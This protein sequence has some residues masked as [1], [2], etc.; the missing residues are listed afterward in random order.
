[1]QNILIEPKIYKKKIVDTITNRTSPC[2]QCLIRV[3]SDEDVC[4]L[5]PPAEQWHSEL[6]LY[7]YPSFSGPLSPWRRF[8]IH[9]PEE[10]K[11]KKD[12]LT[13]KLFKTDYEKGF[14]M[15]FLW[16]LSSGVEFSWTA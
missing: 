1:M 4:R 8:Q 5:L 11:K 6:R 2:P 13:L 10:T 15:H 9:S 3:Q 14:L 12:E 7:S 16:T